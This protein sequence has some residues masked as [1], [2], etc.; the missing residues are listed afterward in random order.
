MVMIVLSLTSMK[1]IFWKD[2][3]STTM[4]VRLHILV[5][6]TGI[7]TSVEQ[8]LDLGL[9]REFADSDQSDSCPSVSLGAALMHAS[10]G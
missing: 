8:E 1:G 6:R 2:L 7:A 5:F 3:T 10:Q 9:W 4:Q